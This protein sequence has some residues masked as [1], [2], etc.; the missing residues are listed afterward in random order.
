[1]KKYSITRNNGEK[2]FRSATSK[3]LFELAFKKKLRSLYDKRTN[4]IKTKFL[5]K[6]QK[7]PVDNN[8]KFNLLFRKDGL[9]FVKC[10]KC[11]LI[12]INPQLNQ[13]GLN[14]IY[15]DKKL[16]KMFVERVLESKVQEEFDK[17]KY[18]KTLNELM[19]IIPKKAKVLDIGCSNGLFLRLC[20]QYDLDP[21]GI[22]IS[23][24]TV[25]YSRNKY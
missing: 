3:D 14:L 5:K 1:M 18:I 21:Q 17:N 16:S 23:E 8:N 25:N 12:F 15:S 22:E 10:Q 13:T 7:C 11:E 20:K 2:Y 9:N 6:I 24:P 4:N 19:K